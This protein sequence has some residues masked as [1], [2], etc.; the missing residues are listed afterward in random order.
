LKKST[1]CIDNKHN[2]DKVAT[3]TNV[4]ERNVRNLLIVGTKNR[5]KG[6]SCLRKLDIQEGAANL[7]LPFVPT[8]QL[9]SE[10]SSQGEPSL[11]N[12]GLSSKANL[13]ARPVLRR[14]NSNSRV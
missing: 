13:T 3:A 7:E 5:G 9:N 4:S 2:S 1:F 14:I 8:A 6:G 10:M 12:P 11:K